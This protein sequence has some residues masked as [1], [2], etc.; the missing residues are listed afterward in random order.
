[1]PLR[2]RKDDIPL[3]VD[4]FVSNIGKTMGKKIEKIED[5]VFERFMNYNWPGNVRELQ[6]VLERMINIAHTNI[7]AADLLPSEITDSKVN[8]DNYKIEPVVKIER[9]L[10][11]R[12]IKSNIPKSE[13]AK[14]LGIARST[15][16][17]KLN[18]I[19][20]FASE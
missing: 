6:N 11:M 8:D 3:L 2:E 14:K 20:N 9:E 7:L 19:K 10:I 5:E 4:C 15:L 12:M 18:E 17:R 16:Y 13:I 1:M